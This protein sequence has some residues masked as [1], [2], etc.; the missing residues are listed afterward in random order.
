[1]ALTKSS[2]VT[3]SSYRADGGVAG[4]HGDLPRPRLRVG[5]LHDAFKTVA[6]ASVEALVSAITFVA[7]L[8]EAQA[9]DLGIAVTAM[10]APLWQAAH[11]AE[12]LTRLY[13]EESAMAHLGLTG[14]KCPERQAS[15]DQRINASAGTYA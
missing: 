2:L 5:Q 6:L 7:T 15:S 13:A 4:V 14:L 9:G 12:T 8:D 1:M 3:T 10:T 11:P